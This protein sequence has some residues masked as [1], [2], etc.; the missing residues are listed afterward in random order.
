MFPLGAHDG[1]SVPAKASMS[2]MK[3][4]G[5]PPRPEPDHQMEVTAV[6]AR[7]VLRFRT[8]VARTNWRGYLEQNTVMRIT[9]D[10]RL[11][12]GSTT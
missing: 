9:A 5:H 12:H 2:T 7:S 1:R 3:D 10:P 11:S 8:V 4:M 6:A